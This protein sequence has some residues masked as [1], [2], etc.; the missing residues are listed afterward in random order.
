MITNVYYS[1][2]TGAFIDSATKGLLVSAFEFLPPTVKT[3]YVDIAGRD[4]LIDLSEALTGRPVY[5]N[6]SGYITFIVLKGSSWDMDAFINAYHGKI[7]R[8][9]TNEDTFHYYIGRATITAM[10]KRLGMLQTFTLTI[11]AEPFFWSISETNQTFS[12]KTGSTSN[13]TLSS[14]SNTASGYPSKTSK[15]ITLKA[16]SVSGCSATYTVPIDDSKLYIIACDMDA[17]CRY[18]ITSTD[19][20]V[21]NTTN[22][23]LIKP[24]Q[25]ATSATVKF[26]TQDTTSAAV[27]D[28]VCLIPL[29]EVRR[30]T[31]NGTGATYFRSPTACRLYVFANSNVTVPTE[32]DLAANVPCYTPDIDVLKIDSGGQT[33]IY[34]AL[35]LASQNDTG[36]LWY[37]QG[38]LA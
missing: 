27:F 22:A 36:R 38:I 15:K 21:H 13:F 11:D 28:N 20:G 10:P 1:G 31:A 30:E 17:N 29:E 9:Y 33:G 2:A 23:R 25:G 35:G 5:Q 14:S 34:V 24:V 19:G 37:R 8:V 16:A 6:R 3:Q 26:Y 18:Y 4:G 12:V 7:M 32:Y